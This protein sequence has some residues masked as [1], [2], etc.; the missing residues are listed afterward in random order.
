MSSARTPASSQLALDFHK[1]SQDA[2]EKYARTAAPAILGRL[3]RQQRERNEKNVIFGRDSDQKRRLTL[4][5]GVLGVSA[6]DVADVTVPR[7][8]EL[9]PGEK[10]RA[11][12]RINRIHVISHM[13][14]FHA[15]RQMQHIVETHDKERKEADHNLLLMEDINA[16]MIELSCGRPDPDR[17]REVRVELESI[18][19]D[20]QFISVY[21]QKAKD[22]LSSAVRFL[23]HA[24]TSMRAAFDVSAGSASLSSARLWKLWRFGQME[25]IDAFAHLREFS[26][27][28]RRDRYLR[29]LFSDYAQSAR[30]SPDSAREAILA[31]NR[32]ARE[33]TNLIAA[34]PKGKDWKEEA[35]MLLD[36]AISGLPEGKEKGLLEFERSRLENPEARIRK[37]QFLASLRY[38]S[39]SLL[40]RDPIYIANELKNTKDK[41]MK[42]VIRF[43]RKGVEALA[44][45]KPEL[46]AWYFERICQSI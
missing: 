34:I 37:M 17:I 32:N 27:R 9:H 35:K 10:F 39:R 44:E 30:Q 40:V 25:K 38:V 20:R 41:Y 26:M 28:I 4:R 6:Y 29:T 21:N 12:D 22:G 45:N 1:C 18:L 42:N 8:Y 2:R 16:I 36:K 43:M 19:N 3:I 23:K 14:I 31:N 13:D 15:I 7:T 5:L 33:A 11:G 24:E 46:A